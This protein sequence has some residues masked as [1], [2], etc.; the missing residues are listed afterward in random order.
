MMTIKTITITT[1]QPTG[2]DPGRVEVGHFKMVGDDNVVLCNEDGF[3]LSEK[4]P[5]GP[6]ESAELVASRLLRR[7]WLSKAGETNFNR[8]LGVL[9]RGIA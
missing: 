9:P 5:I 4:T 6:G 7:K 8:T 3:R 2:D 1:A